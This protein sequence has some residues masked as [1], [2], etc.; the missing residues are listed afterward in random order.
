MDGLKA[1]NWTGSHVHGHVLGH[2]YT[3]FGGRVKSGRSEASKWTVQSNESGRSA[4]MDGHDFR[5]P[6]ADGP[7]VSKWTVIDH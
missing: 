4:K 5:T 2:T 3:F 6:E 7:K 1:S